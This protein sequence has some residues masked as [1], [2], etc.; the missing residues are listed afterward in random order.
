MTMT[1][2][3]I[4]I[5][6]SRGIRLPK[7]VLDQCG[8]ADMVDLAVGHRRITIRPHVSANPRAGWDEAFA[9]MASMR[10]DRP[11]EWPETQWDK[12]EWRW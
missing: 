10:D 4:R 12:R 5:G 2:K 8:I 6:N 1:A 11:P 7:M 3:V 9:Q